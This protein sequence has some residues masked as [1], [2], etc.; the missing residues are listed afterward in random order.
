[1][2]G[3]DPH[4]DFDAAV[5]RAMREKADR[6]VDEARRMQPRIYRYDVSRDLP[7]TEPAV[8]PDGPV[9]DITTLEARP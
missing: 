9:Y 3:Q 4:D 7:A 8:T 6:L 2:P 1:M 5:R